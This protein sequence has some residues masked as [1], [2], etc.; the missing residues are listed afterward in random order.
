MTVR[1]AM[2]EGVAMSAAVLGTC[3]TMSS[4]SAAGA[5]PVTMGGAVVGCCL[6]AFYYGGLYGRPLV[7]SFSRFLLR[8]P[9]VLAMAVGF[10]AV[11]SLLL[12]RLRRAPARD[13]PLFLAVIAVL[14]VT[15]SLAY[16]MMR[17]LRFGERVLVLGACPLAQKIVAEIESQPH[18][19]Q[20]VAG[21]VDDAA[22]PGALARYRHLGTLSDLG[23]I[24]ERVDPD[25]IVVTPAARRSRLPVEP[26]L[27]H[28][29][30]GVV[31]EDGVDAY[32]QLTGKL[33]IESLT[34]KSL[35]FGTGFRRARVSRAMRRALSL[36]VSLTALLVLAP[37][38]ALIALAIRL[39]SPGP[40]LFIQDRVGQAA[41]RFRL[42]KFRTM[43]P[44]GETTSEWARDNEARITRVGRILRKYRL[45]ELPQF[46]NVVRGDMNLVGPRP[47]PVSNFQ[48]FVQ[49]IPYYSLRSVVPPGITGWAQVRYSYANNLE[50][51]TE[52]MRYD[53]YYIKH[54]SL[55][56]D[57]LILSDTV[58]IVLLGRESVPD[59]HQVAGERREDSAQRIAAHAAV[60]EA[61][62]RVTALLAGESG[63]REGRSVVDGLKAD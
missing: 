62:E 42:F 18:R 44:G 57:L 16:G 25:R 2:I 45:D 52:K 49:N 10:L 39:D 48:L 29:V 23:R 55:W 1:L 60:R 11:L 15:R 5:V 24:I 58:K 54:T 53:L 8:L 13:V 34:A 37:L 46:L 12:P 36:A 17:S 4:S 50:E 7:G 6:L 22:L 61:A 28:R 9:A 21:I 63:E 27:E 26:L 38:L 47:H 56:L 59:A 32:E 33:A 30:R 35:I 43:R 51:E 31:V 40:V 14:L 20:V 3:L 19:R 41:R